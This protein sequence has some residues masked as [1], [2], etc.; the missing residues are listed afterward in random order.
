MREE[1]MESITKPS[2]ETGTKIAI[3]VV[4]IVVAIVILMP[5]I[6]ILK[7]SWGPTYVYVQGPGGHWEA[8]ELQGAFLGWNNVNDFLESQIFTGLKNSF[9]IGVCST[10]LTLYF[11]ALTAYAIVAYDWRLREVFNK[12]VLAVMMIPTTI[13]S[14]GFVQMIYKMHMT[15]KLIMFILPAIAAPVT[16]FFMRQY[17]QATDLS[18]IIQSAR[19]DGAGEFRIFNTI[20]LPL[21]KPAFATQGILAFVASWNNLFVPMVVLTEP[22]KMTIPILV[23]NTADYKIILFCCLPPMVIYLLLSKH[24]VDGITLGG[25]KN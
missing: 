1:T 9:I 4:A 20:V 23:R 2:K 17:L 24:I 7:D 10:A 16:V 13:S 14:I 3:Y 19:L 12:F 6:I 25:V 8:H 18:E 15:N 5:F 11:S 21:M 22:A